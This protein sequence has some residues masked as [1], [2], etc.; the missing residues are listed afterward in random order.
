MPLRF[1]MWDDAALEAAASRGLLRLAR[2]DL[3]AGAQIMRRDDRE[4]IVAISGA[5]ATLRSGDLAKATC[6]CAAR[7]I[8]RH[9]LAA[10]LLLREEAPAD[11]PNENDEPAP[12]SPDPLTEILALTQKE[13]IGAFGRALLSRAGESLE[14]LGAPEITRAASSCVV[15]FPGCAE[16]RYVAGLGAAGMVCKAPAAEAKALCAQALLAVRRA[17]GMDGA[18]GEPARVRV[19]RDCA[20]LGAVLDGARGL[21]TDWTRSGLAAAPE[22]LEDLLFDAA[23]GARA[24]ALFR[25]S[26]ELR[27]LSEDVR[28]RRERDAEFQA[29][30]SLRAAA[31]C[32]A[33]VE[34]LRRSP[35]DMNL[36][37]RAREAFEPIGNVALVGCGVETWRTPSGARGATA[38]FYAPE[39]R[40][41]FTASL[42]RASG[43]DPGFAPEQAIEQE[44]VWGSVLAKLGQSEVQLRGAATSPNG[45]LSLSRDVEARLAPARLSREM[46]AQWENNFSDWAALNAFARRVFSPSLRAARRN[47]EI[48]ILTPAEFGRARFDEIAQE[49]V[50]PV[51]DREAA[52][53]D[54]I[55]ENIAH[56]HDRLHAV[57]EFL[58]RKSPDAVFATL[59]RR[60]EA[61]VLFPYA[62]IDPTDQT[63]VSLD[64]R[65]APG[66]A[67]RRAPSRNSASDRQLAEEPA[68]R[69]AA[70]PSARE[71][72]EN[73]FRAALD[74]LLGLCE[75][76]G[77]MHDPGGAAKIATLGEQMEAIGIRPLAVLLSEVAS[78][79]GRRRAEAILIATHALETV[80]QLS[81]IR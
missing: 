74:Q 45:R 60:G 76:G 21:L 44:T 55:V 81:I 40:Q 75:L 33:L 25:L 47:A 12:Q 70:T 14:K 30:A 42:A 65:G 23:I 80:R 2:R 10:I 28:R 9:I 37:G 78:A 24:A 64:R 19:D 15:A 26:A 62:F 66:A 16:V 52:R 34:A 1:A 35:D 4:V 3:A 38:H 68:I 22:A 31:H 46:L 72:T 58:Q 8:C 6:T 20:G 39:R 5:A 36:R 79:E 53:I 11:P 32:F 27:R 71:A 77:R 54:L 63:I 43:Q 17:H 67:D 56:R 13:M 69:R 7:E 57:E 29:S 61:I 59:A 73:M 51:F 49:L 41:W 50:I 18:Q 48:V